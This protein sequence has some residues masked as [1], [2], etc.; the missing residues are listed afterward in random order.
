MKFLATSVLFSVFLCGQTPPPPT[1]APGTPAPPVQAPPPEAPPPAAPVT[2]DTVVAE[3]GDKKLTAAEVDHL[4][5]GLPPQIQQRAR[6]QPD[7]VL[8]QLLI[9]ILSIR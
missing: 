8:T 4:F 3:V 6:M 1:V 2:P 7:K 9:P 5:A